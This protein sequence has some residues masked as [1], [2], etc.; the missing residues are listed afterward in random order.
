M[1]VHS[2]L[3]SAVALMALGACDT[4]PEAPEPG[5]VAFRASG[6]TT[7]LKAAA[8]ELVETSPDF[9]TFQ[10]AVRLSQL[11][12]FDGS[13]CSHGVGRET[14]PDCDDDGNA[15]WCARDCCLDEDLKPAEPCSAFVC[16]PSP[17]GTFDPDCG[18]PWSVDAKYGV[19]VLTL[20]GVNEPGRPWGKDSPLLVQ[21][22]NEDDF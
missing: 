11:P 12:D 20:P 15:L 19:D 21:G 2:I 9:M 18:R 17:L 16:E 5:S 6:E 22:V 13:F 14:R 8:M 1:K 7:E 4:E 10:V 3:I